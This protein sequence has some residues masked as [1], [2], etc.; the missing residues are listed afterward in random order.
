MTWNTSTSPGRANGWGSSSGDAI[1]ATRVW[2]GSDGIDTW[3]PC[4]VIP[5]GAVGRGDRAALDGEPSQRPDDD[6]EQCLYQ[7]A[8][9]HDGCGPRGAADVRGIASGHEHG[10]NGLQSDES[11]GGPDGHEHAARE[12]GHRGGEDGREIRMSRERSDEDRDRHAD[13]RV[14]HDRG[15]APIRALKR[16]E[17][18]RHR[19]DRSECADRRL[20]KENS[21][22]QRDSDADRTSQRRQ[23]F[24]LRPVDVHGR[25]KRLAKSRRAQISFQ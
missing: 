22:N 14:H 3:H 6:H 11:R 18:D 25:R 19:A 1:A 9:E 4:R 13:G 15:A 24:E 8:A 20:T 17:T 2:L 21:D 16:T 7:P 5:E 10:D 23:T 12:G